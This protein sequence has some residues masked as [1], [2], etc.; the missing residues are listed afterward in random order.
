MIVYL[1]DSKNSPRELLNLINNF[2]E[3]IGYKINYKSVAFCFS[4]D[5]QSKKKKIRETTPSI[6]VTNNIKYLDATLSMQVL[7]L[8]LC[9]IA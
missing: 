7:L 8:L 6:K 5:K 3:V 4:K 9:G 2:S 1:S